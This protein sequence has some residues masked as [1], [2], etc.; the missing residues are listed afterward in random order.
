MCCHSPGRRTG[1]LTLAQILDRI[2]AANPNL[3]LARAGLVGAEAGVAMEQAANWPEWSL[4]LNYGAT[5]N[6]AMAF[7]ML[8]NQRA[9]DFAGGFDPDPGHTDNWREEVRVDWLL[10]SADRSARQRSADERS[11]GAAAGM[12]HAD[13]VLRTAGVQAWYGLRAARA[14]EVV[15]NESIAV[16][17]ERLETTERRRAEG[18]ALKAD[19][20]RLQVRLAQARQDAAQARLQAETAHTGLNRLM[21]RRADAPLA[22]AEEGD[23]WQVPQ[24]P[25]RDLMGCIELALDQR[26]DLQAAQSAWQSAQS[27]YDAARRAGGVQVRAF[28]TYGFDSD[29]LELDTDQDSYAYG[30]GVVLPFSKRT[31][32]GEAMARAQVLAARAQ[33]DTLSNQVQAEVRGAL[34]ALQA[35][36]V[37]LELAS[38]AVDTASEAYRIVAE[39]QDAGGATVTD[40]L[41]AEDARRR[42]QV[43]LVATRFQVQIAQ[44]RLAG[45]TGLLP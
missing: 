15:V 27:G 3:D 36:E 1:H 32:A 28:G 39:A 25:T 12:R 21:A 10:W 22:L 8:M 6:P 35:A 2:S 37:Q 41:E 38:T 19:V 20:L 11:A 26:Q 29:T 44:A 18:A 9:V 43:N 16:V 45:A 5:N 7:G 23:A 24:P 42:A 14:M 33:L 31:R 4:G 17:R 40:V 34:S 30:L 13:Q